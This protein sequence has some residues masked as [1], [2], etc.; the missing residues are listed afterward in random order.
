MVIINGMVYFLYSTLLQV[1][2]IL[3]TMV[4]FDLIH[5]AYVG[6]L[7]ILDIVMALRRWQNLKILENVKNVIW[8]K[9]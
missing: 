1:S 8:R 7:C 6:F 9:K 5:D 4:S 2:S 3:Y